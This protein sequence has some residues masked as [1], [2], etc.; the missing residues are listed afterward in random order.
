[1][2]R[3]RTKPSR[4]DA[5]S[6]IVTSPKTTNQSKVVLAIGAVNLFLAYYAFSALG[7]PEAGTNA[8]TE[9]SEPSLPVRYYILTAI[10]VVFGTI[11][12][13]FIR[14]PEPEIRWAARFLACF[15]PGIFLVLIA[16]VGVK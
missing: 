14:Y 10:S 15:L 9:L 1:M 7:S 11:S 5:D 8:V 13:T 12:A 6:D 2:P 3:Y 16:L 4:L